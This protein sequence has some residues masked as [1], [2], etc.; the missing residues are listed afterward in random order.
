[1]VYM[2]QT[3]GL[4]FLF[5]FISLLCHKIC[6]QEI[7]TMTFLVNTDENKTYF[8]SWTVLQ[9]N[10]WFLFSN[11]HRN[12]NVHVQIISLVL[13]GSLQLFCV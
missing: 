7:L 13:Q 2:L 11:T 5:L 9:Y 4:N 10:K 3:A 1:M 12:V 8:N 6:G